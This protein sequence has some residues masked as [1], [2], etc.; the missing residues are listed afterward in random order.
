MAAKTSPRGKKFFTVAQAN[1]ALPLVRAIVRD[2]TALYHNLRERQE[3]M[4][5]AKPEHGTISEMHQEEWRHFQEEYERDEERLR[6]YERELQQL[7]VYLKDYMVGLID[8]PCW[9]DG[10]EVYLCWRQGEPDVAHWHEVDAGFAG[11]QKLMTET[12]KN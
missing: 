4:E 5:R 2:I 3:R 10:H 11:R 8:F 7:G 9:M 12:A 1:A 6:D